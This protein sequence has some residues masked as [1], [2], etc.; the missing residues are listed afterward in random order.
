MCGGVEG[1]CIFFKRSRGKRRKTGEEEEEG[2]G[3]R[4]S[5]R[6]EE[7]KEQEEQERRG[8]EGGQGQGVFLQVMASTMR[9]GG[10]AGGFKGDLGVERRF[11]HI[12]SLMEPTEISLLD[13]LLSTRQIKGLDSEIWNRG[14]GESSFYDLHFACAEGDVYKVKRL[15]DSG[16]C[17]IN[18]RFLELQDGSTPLHWAAT[19]KANTVVI[20]LLE[21]GA[22]P[23]LQTKK[24]M[25]ALHIACQ[26]NHVDTI[27]KLVQ[28]GADIRIRDKTGQPKRDAINTGF[29]TSVLHMKV[30]SE[31]E[32]KKPVGKAAIDYVFHDRKDQH[33]NPFYPYLHSLLQDDEVARKNKMVDIREKMKTKYAAM[34]DRAGKDR[35]RSGGVQP[36]IMGVFS[37]AADTVSHGHGDKKPPATSGSMSGVGITPMRGGAGGALFK[38]GLPSSQMEGMKDSREGERSQAGA[39]G[40]AAPALTP[41]PPLSNASAASALASR[42]SVRPS[43]KKAVNTAAVESHE[44]TSMLNMKRFSVTMPSEEAQVL[45]APSRPAMP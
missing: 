24:G 45:H 17:D 7:E 12:R 15:I 30:P 22:D 16:E 34:E 36:S 38:G 39:S 37:M 29:N 8:E 25:T 19:N 41:A 2:E 4:R 26:L 14:G 1:A 13:A 20:A 27:T 35:K 10:G 18:Q 9:R 40:E 33:A 31:E 44:S 28:A 21:R 5:R 3:R 42:T 43:F 6:R 11:P 32:D 23:N